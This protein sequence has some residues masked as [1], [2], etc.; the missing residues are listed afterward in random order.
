MA[1]IKF[2]T[3]LHPFQNDGAWQFHPNFFEGKD[4]NGNDVC[5]NNG[6][7]ISFPVPNEPGVY[8]VGVK[9]PV[10]D[11]KQF[12]E[13]GKPIDKAVE[14]FCPLYVGIQD[15]LSTK[16]S[17]HRNPNNTS[18]YTGELNSFKELWNLN[19][20]PK[21]FYKGIQIWN[22]KWRR[23]KKTVED[24]NR[25]D[26]LGLFMT[27]VRDCAENCLIWFPNR[28]F[29]NV[30]LNTDLSNYGEKSGHF[31]SVGLNKDLDTINTKEAKI[32]KKL[33][34]EVKLKIENNFWYAFIT[35]EYIANSILQSNNH[36]LKEVADKYLQERVWT[37]KMKNAKGNTI[38]KNGPG[39]ILC[40]SIENATN[41]ALA[42]NG[43]YTYAK[44]NTPKHPYVI[45]FSNLKDDLVRMEYNPLIINIIP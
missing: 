21:I 44:A 13:N 23:S 19:E 6:N 7:I 11:P 8:I 27:E 20:E 17:G 2:T 30:Y 32:L 41:K 10:S 15:D 35:A 4:A 3:N 22:E 26:Q 45:D 28:V 39:K 36:P 5:D 24:P 34:E 40:E 33:I 14:R 12:D 16:I 9:I 18:T 25:I 29:F 42:Q 43:I 31:G 38:S 1:T 37:I